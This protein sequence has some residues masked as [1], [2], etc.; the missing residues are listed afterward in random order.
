MYCKQGNNW[1]RQLLQCAFMS[2]LIVVA[3]CAP[4]HPTT[5]EPS[6]GSP[7]WFFKT[8]P[9]VPPTDSRSYDG[10]LY[11]QK[12]PM[13][14][15]EDI[16][17]T[18]EDRLMIAGTCLPADEQKVTAMERIVELAGKTSIVVVNE[19]H[20]FPWH[21][22]FVAE[23]ATRL[24]IKG[25]EYFAA[26]DFASN[27]NDHP[28]EE[29]ARLDSGFYSAEPVYGSLIRVVKK[30]DYILVPYE[31]KPARDSGTD[32][33]TAEKVTRREEGQAI[34]LIA[35]IFEGN[36]DARVLIY[37]GYSHA[38]EVPIPSFNHTMM[39]WMAAR[40]KEKTG[41]DPLTIDQVYCQSRTDNI[42][43]AQATDRMPSGAFD[44][45]VAFPA[46]TF[47]RGRPEWRLAAGAKLVDLPAELGTF[48]ERAI[49]EAR[50]ANEPNEAVPVDRLLLAPGEDVPLLLPPG[51]F[52]VTV[53]FE[54]G[55][56]EEEFLI[57][58]D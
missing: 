2:L 57:N 44:L 45:T 15:R 38:A 56:N 37:V 29:F 47:S 21:R 35:R 40:L 4:L 22:E 48:T 52:R 27:V 50:F 5:T 55:N 8:I 58:V 25:Y 54:G 28:D 16:Q 32:E 1:F 3:G 11:V 33:T 43:L 9:S 10:Q 41:I 51:K 31:Y 26:E 6:H 12:L 19:A 20:D 46:V 49:V 14:G 17:L 42:Q 18:L 34:N 24:R 23:I 36:A 7:E 39:S 53:F 13:V 30:L